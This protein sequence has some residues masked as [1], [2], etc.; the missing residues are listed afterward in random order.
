MEKE[1]P[2]DELKPFTWYHGEGRFIG[3]IGYWT[4]NRFVGLNVAFSQ[5]EIAEACYGERGFSPYVEVL[6]QKK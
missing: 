5:Y 2:Q 6:C 1:I 3:G 4:G